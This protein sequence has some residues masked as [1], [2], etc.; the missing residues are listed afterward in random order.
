M[1]MAL[2]YYPSWQ[3]LETASF[4]VAAPLLPER[5]ID[6]PVVLSI[7]YDDESYSHYGDKLFSNQLL[8]RLVTKLRR[9]GV[10]T[11]ALAMPLNYLQTLENV[12]TFKNDLS[13]YPKKQQNA[14]RRWLSQLDPDQSLKNAISKAGNAVIFAP[15]VNT[16]GT[17]GKTVL[18]S[19]YFLESPAP[20]TS[21]FVGNT[22]G[23]LYHG[24]GNPALKPVLPNSLFL[25]ESQA[26]G[27]DLPVQSVTGNHLL[28]P[29]QD[30]LLPGFA[31]TALNHFN[32]L[33]LQDLSILGTS[34]IKTGSLSLRTGPAYYYV[35]YPNLTTQTPYPQQW[36]LARYLNGANTKSVFKDKLVVVAMAGSTEFATTV[37]YWNMA[38]T[39]EPL[40]KMLLSMTSGNQ[41]YMPEWFYLGQKL[42]LIF[43]ATGLYFLVTRCSMRLTLTLLAIFSV[44][45]INSW[46]IVLTVRSIW[47]PLALPLTFVLFTQSLLML[48]ARAHNRLHKLAT[49]VI[50]ARS[51]LARS[52]QSQGQ[53]DQAL[54]ELSKCQNMPALR[55]PL[56]Q[57]ALDMERR[58]FFN[59]AQQVYEK[60]A[61][62]DANYRDIKQRQESLASVPAQVGGQRANA[63]A[64]VIGTMVANSQSLEKP[65]LGRYRIEREL[66]QGA[67]GVVYLGV[68]PKIGRQVAIKTLSLMDEFDIE[69]LQDVQQ[70]FFRE[71][72]AAGRLDHPNIITIYDAGEEHDLAY[73]AMDYAPGSS[74]EI[75]TKQESLL[76]ADTV[77]T[78]AAEVAQALDYAHERNV[79]H[80]DIKPSNIIFDPQS[81]SVKVTD[82]GIAF[83]SD[84]SKTK[85]GLILGS[86][87]Y[88]SPEQVAGKK[89]DGRSDLYSLGVTI[90]QLLTG[91]LPFVG[92]SL[93][94]L[95]YK[96][97]NGKAPRVNSLRKDLNSC[98]GRVVTKAMQ[99]DPD[100][101]Y[102]SGE[103]MAAALEK[104]IAQ[105]K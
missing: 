94:S 105:L 42:L 25:A 30:K 69:D 22:R 24:H 31:L 56:Y 20:P 40:R 74:L 37:P 7:A 84:D 101:R 87:S 5:K 80:R 49:E 58:R 14:L 34:G 60:I 15:L 8:A 96:I 47:L 70:R 10:H 93:A 53:L 48:Q 71:A 17:Q 82:F 4:E 16:T 21:S 27:F 6:Q 99:R 43:F 18:P 13:D 97:T 1:F 19:F 92:D 55:E 29:E 91:Q 61:L 3:A 78:I 23:L 28:Y 38:M 81:Q 44:I 59:K 72:E 54:H 88:M 77:L 102:A 83:L 90:F 26:L 73:I 63:T 50:E 104:C 33:S 41:I 98:T 85:T 32:N 79:V 75:Y 65:M 62:I 66:G 52:L 11:I 9:D 36:S 86:P 68:D 51:A 100:K 57:L 46:L 12:A 2:S 95:M 35:P 39:V 64:T 45:I 67:M 89:L 103:E 76:P